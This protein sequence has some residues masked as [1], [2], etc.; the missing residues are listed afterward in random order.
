MTSTNVP[1]K[2]KDGNF[3]FVIVHRRIDAHK[4]SLTNYEIIVKQ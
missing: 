3:A 4:V 1:S 2:T